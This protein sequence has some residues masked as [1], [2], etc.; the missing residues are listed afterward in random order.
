M[1]ILHNGKTPGYQS[2]TSNVNPRIII[3][4]FPQMLEK[5]AV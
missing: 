5:V 2:L 1:L 3:V 4:V